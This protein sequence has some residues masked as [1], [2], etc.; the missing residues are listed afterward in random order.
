MKYSK[1]IYFVLLLAMG[2]STST[3]QVQQ[4][5]PKGDE[6][7]ASSNQQFEQEV[8]LLVNQIR[9][10]RGLRQLRLQPELTN[11]ARYHAKD[12]SVDNYFEHDSYDRLKNGRKKRIGSFSDRLD[13]F[14]STEWYGWAEN[15]AMGHSS[16]QAVMKSW[17]KSRGHRVNLLN[18]NY[19]YIGIAYINGYWVQNFGDASP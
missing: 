19:E 3:A 13:R 14:S 16:A 1:F 12:M 4:G 17:M 11:A 7:F 9:K 10:R 18:A 2:M 5:L 8:L 15:I 6:R